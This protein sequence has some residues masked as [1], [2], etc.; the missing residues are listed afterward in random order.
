MLAGNPTGE[1]NEYIWIERCTLLNCGSDG[2]TGSGAIHAVKNTD[3]DAADRYIFIRD[4]FIESGKV[5]IGLDEADD[6]LIS[7]CT[8]RY[9]KASGAGGEGIALTSSRVRVVGNDVQPH[10]SA[11]AAASCVLMQPASNQQDVEKDFVI[12]ANRLQNLDENTST[13]IGVVCEFDDAIVNGLVAVGN[14][15]RDAEFGIHVHHS[16]EPDPADAGLKNG[17]F[18]HNVLDN[19]TNIT[20]VNPNMEFGEVNATIDDTP[21]E[22]NVEGV[23]LGAEPTEDAQMSNARRLGV[24]ATVFVLGLLHI[25]QGCSA[26]PQTVHGRR[27]RRECCRRGSER[28]DLWTLGC[29]RTGS[30]VIGP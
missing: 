30:G 6:V 23:R 21:A 11:T 28:S 18:A 1:R 27:H 12:V 2:V 25:Q 3:A 24:L 17:R 20:K 26:A 15:C 10:S 19:I 4:C 13:F 14:M 16:D 9:G 29:R 5:G 22:L 7:G 8:I